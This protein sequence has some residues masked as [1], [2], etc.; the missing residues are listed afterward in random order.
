MKK[1]ILIAI[2]FL[3]T[4]N[5]SAQ[6]YTKNRLWVIEQNKIGKTY[7]LKN[8]DS[9][10]TYLKYLGIIHDV[11][12]KKYKVL[13]SIWIWGLSKRATN[14]ILIYN[15]KNKYIGQ[16]AVTMTYDLP[17]KIINNKLAFLNADAIEKSVCNSTTYIDFSHGPPKKIFVDC[18][19]DSGSIWRFER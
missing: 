19:G 14:R 11:K 5:V 18:N 17:E 15:I 2:L 10:V 16:Y 7:L 1:I 13:T 12:N 3:L 8:P 9:T 4:L 6:V